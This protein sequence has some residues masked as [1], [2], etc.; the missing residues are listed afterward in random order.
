MHKQMGFTLIELIFALVLIGIVSVM[1]GRVLL[2]G[3]QTFLTT[4]NIVET[5]WQGVIALNRL[6]DDI[7]TIRSSTDIT[8]IQATQFSFVDNAGNTVQ[9]QLSGSVLTRNGLS[10]ASGLQA[11]ALGY[12]DS[13]GATTTTPANVRYV[14]VS[15]TVADDGMTRNFATLAAT[16]GMR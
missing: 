1:G 12:L 14:S 10:L 7:H 9:Y 6:A 11:F 3:Y 16:R 5:G 4:Q 13:N 8:T 2:S 15:L